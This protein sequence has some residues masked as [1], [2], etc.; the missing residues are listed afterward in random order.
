MAIGL[1]FWE[2]GIGKFSFA[3]NANFAVQISPTRVTNFESTAGF[4]GLLFELIDRQELFAFDAR[5]FVF[6]VASRWSERVWFEVGKKTQPIVV[7]G[8]R[9]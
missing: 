2:I 3:L 5:L 9:R 4:F 7:N 1:C 8:F 6:L